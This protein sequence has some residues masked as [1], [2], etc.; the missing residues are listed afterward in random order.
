MLLQVIVELYA[1]SVSREKAFNFLE[2]VH[3]L[4]QALLE[5]QPVVF[6]RGGRGSRMGHAVHAIF[7]M[8]VHWC[9]R[10]VLGV[11]NNKKKTLLIFNGYRCNVIALV[12]LTRLVVVGEDTHLQFAVCEYQYL[13]DLHT[14]SIERL[15]ALTCENRMYIA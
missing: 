10:R 2:K 14:A 1:E 13:R 7:G 15:A 5:S 3:R 8:R 6:R 9:H 12:R 4:V 11:W